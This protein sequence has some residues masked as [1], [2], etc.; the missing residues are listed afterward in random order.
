MNRLAGFNAAV[1]QVHHQERGIQLRPE[2]AQP[3]V[4]DSLSLQLPDGQSLLDASSMTLKRGERVLIVGPSGCGKS[5]LLRAIAGI[6]PY[7]SG[8]IGLDATSRALFLP[9]RSYIP[10]GTLREALSYPT[11]PP[12]TAMSN[13]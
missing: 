7:G 2:S 1:D 9:Q 13:C 5:T 11:S 10:I 6:W 8:T 3:L 4:L 12:N